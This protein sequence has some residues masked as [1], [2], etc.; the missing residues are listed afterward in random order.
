VTRY[1]LRGRIGCRQAKRPRRIARSALTA[2]GCYVVSC[3][4]GWACLGLMIRVALP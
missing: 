1:T 4:I 2:I 3:V